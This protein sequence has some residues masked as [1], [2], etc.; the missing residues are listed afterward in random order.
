MK[1]HEVMVS[2]VIQTAPEETIASAAKRML[3][4]SVSCLVATADGMVK[5]IITARDLLSCLAHSH[6]PDRCKVSTHMSW[7]VIVL[8]SDENHVTAMDVMRLKKINRMPLARSGKLVGIVSMSDLA[9]IASNEV[10][11]LRVSLDF[12]TTVIRAQSSRSSTS[13]KAA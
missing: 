12:C 8:H 7:P 1:L 9:A 10:E 2:E 13:H 6:D 3:T 5:G 4:L 11:K